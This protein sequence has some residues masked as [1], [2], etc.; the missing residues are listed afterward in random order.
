MSDPFA[1][2]RGNSRRHSTGTAPTASVVMPVP[3]NAPTPPAVH[4]TL[5]KPTATW[6][7]CDASG[8]WLGLVLRFDPPGKEK[9]FRPLSVRSFDGKLEWWWG[10]W[11]APRPLY[12][13]QR[14]AEK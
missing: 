8:R 9:E 3:D 2:I 1:P 7:Y 13:L 12:G 10:S 14:L 11:P 5:G 6:A 4:P